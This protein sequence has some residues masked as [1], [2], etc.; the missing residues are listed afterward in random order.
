MRYLEDWVNLQKNQKSKYSQEITSVEFLF[1]KHWAPHFI[2]Y[3]WQWPR[4]RLVHQQHAS[5]EMFLLLKKKTHPGGGEY[6]K[7][8]NLLPDFLSNS[9][10]GWDIPILQLD[11]LSHFQVV[12]SM[13]TYP[14][15]PFILSSHGEVVS[16]G[17]PYPFLVTIAMKNRHWSQ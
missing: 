7:T 13:S 11:F 4:T 1:L 16:P 3:A 8:G 2:A 12:P 14:N 9:I 17:F 15:H 10:I 6:L 5:S